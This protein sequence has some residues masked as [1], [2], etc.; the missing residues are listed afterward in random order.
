MGIDI[1]R[2]IG[3]RG[4][5]RELVSPERGGVVSGIGQAERTTGG[6]CAPGGS[7]PRLVRLHPKN[8]GTARQLAACGPS[9][10]CRSSPATTR[11]CSDETRRPGRSD[12]P[13]P[14]GSRRSGLADGVRQPGSWS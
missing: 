5:G 4:R 11:T 8:A 3:W 7:R 10:R 14:P 12:L 1:R 13:T 9:R 6:P 2:L